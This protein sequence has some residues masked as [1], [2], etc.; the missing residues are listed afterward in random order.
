ML[1]LSSDLYHQCRET[2]MKC[3]EFD[4]EISLRTIFVTN[5]LSPYR[6]RLTEVKSKSD[7]IDACIDFI[8]SQTL[9]D[10]QPL[11][12]LF[13]LT[14]RDRYQEED[15]IYYE[16]DRLYKAV[17]ADIAQPGVSDLESIS[18]RA[19]FSDIPTPPDILVNRNNLIIGVH[20]D[21]DSGRRVSLYGLGG[22]GKTALAAYVARERE[23]RG[24]RVLWL[25]AGHRDI[26][27]LCD[28]IGRKFGDRTIPALDT[29]EKLTHVQWLLRQHAIHLLVLDDV[30]DKSGDSSV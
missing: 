18:I 8:L 19:A 28:E 5:E 1:R 25:R 20:R 16:L 29:K 10:A 15:S 30:W 17:E 26:D 3:S 14:L 12:P 9:K 13:L 24:E 7:R 23:K 21:L 2:F 11:L 27:I 6:N 4:S 22:M